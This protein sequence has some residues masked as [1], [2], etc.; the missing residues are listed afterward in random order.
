[1]IEFIEE[2]KQYIIRILHIFEILVHI[3]NHVAKFEH[4][5]TVDR[6]NIWQ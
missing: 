5:V 6:E 2:F 4:M 3:G 1:M